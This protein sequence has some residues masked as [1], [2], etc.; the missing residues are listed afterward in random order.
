MSKVQIDKALF[1]LGSKK[2]FLLKAQKKECATKI[3]LR[4][5]ISLN[6]NTTIKWFHDFMGI[7]YHFYDVHT[8]LL[9]VFSKR[10]TLV[11][12]WNRIIKWWPDDEIKMRFVE[13]EENDDS[14]QFTL[15][16]ESRILAITWVFLK[17]LK[18]SEHYKKFKD[19]YD[20]A[21]NLGFALYIP[22]DDFYELELFDYKKRVTDVKFLKETEADQDP[23]VFRARQ[24]LRDL[25]T[26][27]N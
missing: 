7:G 20:G 12:A 17:H 9:L 4:V 16:S 5:G 8:K 25:E 14:F 22:R 11:D 15:Y 1:N 23:L 13:R 10:K 6:D 2:E 19:D 3:R 21:A 26:G 24:I 18:A 27:T